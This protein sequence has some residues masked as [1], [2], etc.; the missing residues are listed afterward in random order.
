MNALRRCDGYIRFGLMDS[1]S[2][3][4]EIG[5]ALG[6][7][8][9]DSVSLDQYGYL[10][11]NTP[12][13]RSYHDCHPSLHEGDCVRMEVDLDSIPRTVKFFVNGE[14][15]ECY[16]SGIPSSVRIGFSVYGEGLSFR[17]DNISRLSRPTP[18]SEGMNEVKW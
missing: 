12:S 3:I 14:A 13:I 4:P 1:T 15:G 11:Y 5:E 2:R 9:H 18:L 6:C 7:Q 10:N 8:V 16:M 17:I